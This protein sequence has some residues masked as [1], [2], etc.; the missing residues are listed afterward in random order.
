MDPQGNLSKTF[1]LSKKE[2]NSKK[3]FMQNIDI[4]NENIIEEWKHG[5]LSVDVIPTNIESNP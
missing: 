2:A 3:L 5:Q 4:I 1:K